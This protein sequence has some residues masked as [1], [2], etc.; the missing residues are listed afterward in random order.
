MSTCSA[1]CEASGTLA[2]A[3][4]RIE[5]TVRTEGAAAGGT[6]RLVL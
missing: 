2:A 3:N 4:E 1:T 5:L 6:P